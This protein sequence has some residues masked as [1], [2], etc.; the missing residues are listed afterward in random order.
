VGDDGRPSVLVVDDDP[1]VSRVIV[2]ILARDAF[3]VAVVRAAPEA[4]A[5]LEVSRPDV[6]ILDIELPGMSG[7]E[8]LLRL[9]EGD[10]PPVILL[11]GRGEE[12][13]RVLGLDLG[14]EDYV[15]KPFLPR[16]LAARVRGVLRRRSQALAA[17][18]RLDLGPLVIDPVERTVTMHDEVVELTPRE[19]ELL[20][21]LARHPRRVFSRT[22]LLERVWGS[23][24]EWQDPAT[25]TEHVRRLRSKI[26]KDP[27][28]TR[29]ITTVR[30]AG[31]RFDPTDAIY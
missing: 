12:T 13:D 4:L 9:R 8:L 25:V 10:C 26:E 1:V 14:A 3:D 30:G 23:K 5:R 28:A 11:T 20:F 16:E 27:S 19:F 18:A 24:G 17:V 21:H 15:V 31:Y 22:E 6:I 29:W 7:L 2:E